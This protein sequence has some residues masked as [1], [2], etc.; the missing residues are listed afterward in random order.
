MQSISH[1]KNTSKKDQYL[2]ILLINLLSWKIEVIIF[3][4][5]LLKYVCFTLFAK[6]MDLNWWIQ[7]SHMTTYLATCNRFFI[8][9]V[10]DTLETIVDPCGYWMSL[11]LYFIPRKPPRFPFP[12]LYRH[13]FYLPINFIPSSSF[14]SNWISPKAPLRQMPL[15]LRKIF[16]KNNC[17]FNA[18]ITW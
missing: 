15:K 11:S 7:T 18:N 5:N 14:Y 16:F 17:I 1:S 13:T 6:D 12:Y 9:T 10:S 3:C 4:C 8:V 2:R